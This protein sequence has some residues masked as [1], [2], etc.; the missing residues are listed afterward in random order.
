MTVG[1]NEDALGGLRAKGRQGLPVGHV[2]GEALGRWID[3]MEVKADY[4]AVIAA[5]SAAATRFGDEDALDL[6]MT[7]GDGFR[8][9]AFA[10]PAKLAT[11]R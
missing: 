1:A 4:G 5:D 10:C 11:A 7:P 3:V 2:D 6:L 9:T 8:D